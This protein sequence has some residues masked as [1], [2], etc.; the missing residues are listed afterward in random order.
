MTRLWNTRAVSVAA[1]VL[2]AGLFHCFPSIFA[3]AAQPG[4]I[5]V[6]TVMVQ[7]EDEEPATAGKAA[8]EALKKAMGDVPIKAVLIS[9]CFEDREYKEE[10]LA[11][12]RDV[13]PAEV[14]FGG[15]TYGSF[16]Q[17]GCTDFDAVCLLGIGGDGIGVSARLV[18]EMGTSKLLPDEDRNEI[19]DRLHA[20]GEKLAGKLRRTDRDR[21]C[22]V[23]A[24]AHS[25]KNQFLVEGLQKGLG[26]QF[27][28]TG[29]CANKNAGQTFVYFKGKIHQDA[30]LALL[31]SGDFRVG[32]SGRQ[33]NQEQQV[34]ATAEEGAQEALDRLDGEP[35]AV[36]A[37]NCAGRRSKLND[38]GE[39]LAAMQKALGTNVPLFGCYCAGEIGPVDSP[40][41]EK[42]ALSGGSGWHLMFAIIG[43]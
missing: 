32:L 23:V 1:T 13:L 16:T 17:G 24:D 40:E 36:M 42:D 3:R 28:I 19:R 14:L 22:V 37:F 8:A 43:K 25:P 21:L 10:L 30:A 20:A 26:K 15:A 7:D 38:Y 18:T 34:I 5:V 41:Q 33:A 9:E 29:G 2:A 31:L 11:G 6:K 39:E 35:M 27:P 12:L 4:A